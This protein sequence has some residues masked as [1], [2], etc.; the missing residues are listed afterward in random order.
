MPI[1]SM[2]FW[3]LVWVLVSALVGGVTGGDVLIV[4]RKAA[5]TPPATKGGLH[6]PQGRRVNFTTHLQDGGGK[7][8]DIQ[9]GLNIGRGT[10]SAY[11]GAM[12]C[13]ISGSNVYSQGY[14]W[15]S[16]DGDEIEIGPWSR[17]N[18]KVYRRIKVY[19]DQPLARWLDIFENPTTNNISVQ[20]SVYTNRNYTIRNTTTNSGKGVFGPR[21][22][23]M[24][25]TS[26]GR[27]SPTV[28]HI[29]C[30]KHSKLRP[31]VQVQSN[32][33]YARYRLTVPAGKT[34]VLCHFLAQAHGT[35]AHTKLLRTFRPYKV[36]KDLPPG[37]RIKDLTPG[38]RFD[39]TLCLAGGELVL[40]RGQAVD[41]LV[42]YLKDLDWVNYRCA[43]RLFNLFPHLDRR[44]MAGIIL[45]DCRLCYSK[46][47]RHLAD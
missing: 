35:D 34:V 10:N 17:N 25:T 30:G 7:Q 32:S 19:K 21:D 15:K 41:D 28:L 26:S 27:S 5:G 42:L 39:E 18:V 45:L 3:I 13:Q 36:L 4:A 44:I 9:S 46:L 33:V 16:A 43:E 8:W 31:S 47:A 22:W 29:L 37:V 24:I 2:S 12:Y 1:R 23:A 38:M 14:G 11:S 6:I 20:I 40:W